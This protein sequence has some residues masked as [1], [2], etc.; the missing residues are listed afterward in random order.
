MHVGT[1]TSSSSSIASAT[2]RFQYVS[3]I[4]RYSSD[5]VESIRI[6]LTHSAEACQYSFEAFELPRGD[7]VV[8]KTR[9]HLVDCPFGKLAWLP[10]GLRAL[11]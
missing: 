6:L 2:I 9:Q 7:P 8:Y 5:H 4:F 3:A 11:T 1:L 10:V